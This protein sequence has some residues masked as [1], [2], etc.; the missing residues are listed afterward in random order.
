M[1][2]P[3]RITALDG[4]RGLA[5]IF[6]VL[7][8]LRL[9]PILELLG[10]LGFLS[11]II[12]Q[13]G[14]IGVS[15]FFMLSGFLIG[16]LYSSIP[17]S[18]QFIRKRYTRI[19]PPFLVMA[20]VIAVARLWWTWMN[21]VIVVGLILFTSWAVGSGWRW[22]QHHKEREHQVGRWLFWSFIAAQ[23]GVA[24]WYLVVLPQTPAPVFYNV[25][26]D[27]QQMIATFVI[28]ATMT[29]P[30][31]IYVGQLD[32]VYW[33]L[34]IEVLFYLLYPLLILPLM[35]HLQSQKNSKMSVMLILLTTF[36]L[37]LGL[38]QT[39][40][41]VLGMSILNFGSFIFFIA[42]LTLAHVRKDNGQWWQHFN[43]S[44]KRP[45]LTR[46][47]STILGLASLFL[48]PM[49]YYYIPQQFHPLT[50]M[51][52][53]VPLGLV[54]A[55]CLVDDN[56]LKRLLQKPTLIWFGTISYSLYLT[57][58]I[59]IEIFTKG[60]AVTKFIPSLIVALLSTLIAI[61]TAIW[62][63]Y[64]V[65]LPYF[66][67][68]KQPT[69]FV[70]PSWYQQLQLWAKGFLKKFFNSENKWQHHAFFKFVALFIVVICCIWWSNRPPL[71]VF[72]QL[73]KYRQPI[74]E[75]DQQVLVP[76]DSQVSFDFT[77]QN[78][79]VGMVTVDIERL[80]VGYEHKNERGEPQLITTVTDES[81]TQIAANQRSVLGLSKD[82]YFPIGIPIQVDAVGQTYTV[83]F[84]IDNPTSGVN[85]L[86]GNNG[87]VTIGSVSFPNKAALLADPAQL[88][89]FG[90]EFVSQ[91][92]QEKAAQ[93]QLLLS[94]PFFGIVGYFLVKS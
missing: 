2:T 15:L 78:N 30:L 28:N 8:H 19:F 59:I 27:W 70:W 4:L 74:A 69:E 20:V 65:E 57:H 60:G 94:V 25:W 42:G 61:I 11:P 56:P 13:N 81:G 73:E 76:A 40:A 93:L 35:G 75:G 52:L 54:M 26:T 85:V 92:F 53:V 89:T 90:T 86:L 49:V 87:V 91:P 9:D 12:N 72:S 3:K 46:H 31:G 84:S 14:K 43:A 24:I 58:T 32:G 55:L 45:G 71:P 21:P 16:T 41:N 39:F 34:T 44:I 79:N 33:T 63:H 5:I 36:L 67:R 1:P 47:L 62:L 7:N 50:E 29:L 64:W 66:S 68:S 77:P 18:W 38:E 17:S 48:L 10:P 37:I 23:V 51:V 22:L 82:D 80:F 6:V 83:T 88:I